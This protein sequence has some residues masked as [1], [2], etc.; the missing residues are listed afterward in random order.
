MRLRLLLVIVLRVLVLEEDSGNATAVAYLGGIG[1]GG[2]SQCLEGG[3]NENG[4]YGANHTPKVP[5]VVNLIVNGGGKGGEVPR[6][7]ELAQQ[8]STVED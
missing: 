4:Q 7:E 6:C 3:R 2:D 8:H 1:S 5:M